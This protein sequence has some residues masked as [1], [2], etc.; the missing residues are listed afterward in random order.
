MQGTNLIQLLAKCY[1]Y[2]PA[3]HRGCTP[4]NIL[5][6]YLMRSFPL[7]KSSLAFLCIALGG[8]V[9]AQGSLQF[10]QVRL[11]QALDSVPQNKVWK[12][13]SAMLGLSQG[14]RVSPTFYVNG[15]TIVLGYDSYNVSR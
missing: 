8:S 3:H 13:E 5:Y 12:V 9:F 1:L 14:I 15:D 6:F 10:N 11:I 4:K 7:L 2:L